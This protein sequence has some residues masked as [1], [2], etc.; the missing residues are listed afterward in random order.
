[1]RPNV[2]NYGE[3]G[4]FTE[5]LKKTES[6]EQ[7]QGAFPTV[8]APA[9][10]VE[11]FTAGGELARVR[12][13]QADILMLVQGHNANLASL[14]KAMGDFRDQVMVPI[15][16]ELKFLRY[17]LGDKANVTVSQMQG[18]LG[19]FDKLFVGLLKASGKDEAAISAIR[20]ALGIPANI[21]SLE[22]LEAEGRPAVDLGSMQASLTTL[23]TQNQRLIELNE[24]QAQRHKDQ[25][26]TLISRI[27][28]LEG[29]PNESAAG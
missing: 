11:A 10:A 23:M 16:D 18:I 19:H 26:E 9:S 25:V 28:R 4:T 6:E 14:N 24:K 22:Q 27:Q 29:A 1:M 17:N 7:G 8:H 15:R 21:P 12:Q 13:D 5:A 3:T 20:I 2:S